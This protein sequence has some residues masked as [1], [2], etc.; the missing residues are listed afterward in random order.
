[1]SEDD[2]T[3]KLFDDD[4]FSPLGEDLVGVYDFDPDETGFTGDEVGDDMV[5]TVSNAAN[6]ATSLQDAAERLYDL[7]DEL[8]AFSAEGWEII[9]EIVNGQ[10]TAV[11]FDVNG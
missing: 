3:G 10:G 11:R 8:L 6:G 5:I 7:A 9:D 4:L 1:M 2:Y